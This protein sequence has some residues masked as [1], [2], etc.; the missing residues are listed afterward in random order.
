MHDI[1][2][3]E[4]DGK[5][6]LS[7]KVNTV[8]LPTRDAADGAKCFITGN[9]TSQPVTD[10]IPNLVWH[11]VCGSCTDVLFYL[12]TLFNIFIDITEI[13]HANLG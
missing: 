6:K 8:C 12:Y 3:L 13:S 11:G 1:A 7:D 10:N 4:L 9:V 2:L 5:V